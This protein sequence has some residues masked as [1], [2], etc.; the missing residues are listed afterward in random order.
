MVLKN[1][2][3]GL[4]SLLL[5]LALG[6]GVSVSG[7]CPFNSPFWGVALDGYPL[8]ED[9]LREIEKETGLPSHL[10]VFFLQWPAPADAGV[11]NFPEETLEAIWN[12]GAV[13]CLTWEPMSY[14]NGQEKM[15]PYD[16]II[17]GKY[18]SYILDFAGQA[19]LWEKPFM[20]RF[21]HEMN[22]DR[23]HWGTEKASYGP[24]SPEVYKRLFRHVVTLF[25]KAG[26]KNVMWVFCPNTESVP[27]MSYDPRA[28]WNRVVNYY[29][30]N[31]YVDILGIDGYN[32]GTSQTK[33]KHG[34]NSRWQSFEEIFKSV[35][36]ELCT[37]APQKPIIIFETASVPQGGDKTLWIKDAF[38]TARKWRIRGIVWFHVLKDADWRIHSGSDKDYAS[39]IR[40][41]VSAPQEW[42]R[43]CVK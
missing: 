42:L 30:G 17:S 24:D 2:C 26:A 34:W 25:R 12:T 11:V 15:I 18:D 1:I 39:I 36:G 31:E 5:F 22:I 40:R 14:V 32:W 8:T 23:Y 33:E 4:T 13:P 19:R 16:A 35:Y 27:D 20:I 3:I 21:A 10:V 7:D 6:Y 9:R 28:S 43:S 38:E 29:P 37:L 41:G